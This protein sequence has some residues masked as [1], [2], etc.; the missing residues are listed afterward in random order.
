[1]HN[2]TTTYILKRTQIHTLVRTEGDFIS[3]KE[4]EGKEITESSAKHFLRG[5]NVHEHH[6]YEEINKILIVFHYE[7]E[8]L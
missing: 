5:R 4:T 6:N 8:R 1:M 7:G 3:S 2:K